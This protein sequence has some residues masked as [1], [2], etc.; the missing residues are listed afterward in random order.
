MPPSVEEL[1]NELAWYAD[2]LGEVRDL[3]GTG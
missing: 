1:N 3:S 2:L